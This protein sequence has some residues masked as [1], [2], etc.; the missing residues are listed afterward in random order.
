MK[1]IKILGISG[2]LRKESYNL[3][4]LTAAAKLLP[5]EVELEIYSL[6]KLPMYN[7]DLEYTENPAV[8]ELKTKLKESDAVLFS[9]PEY[10]YSIPGALKNA[11]DIASRP[12][13]DNTWAG[14]PA[15]IMGA[16]VGNLGT[17]RMQY[18]LRQ[19]LV[20]LDMHLLNKP[21]LM[22]ST[23][24]DKI[25]P[26]GVLTDEHTQEKIAEL[27]IALVEWTKKL[28]KTE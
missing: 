17:S 1:T 3:S 8:T 10:N 20:G 24:Q 13:G 5:A 11:I 26:S 2:S 28:S 9:G 15:A 23:V 25:S 18:H 27:L 12:W 16:T 4:L 7:Q 6:D 22:I 14:K 21:E 19:V